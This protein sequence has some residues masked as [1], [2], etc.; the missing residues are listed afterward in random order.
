[1]T[2]QDKLEVSASFPNV[3]GLLV[4]HVTQS[5]ITPLSFASRTEK[6]EWH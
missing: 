3:A 2:P 6:L 1:M 5:A 4:C